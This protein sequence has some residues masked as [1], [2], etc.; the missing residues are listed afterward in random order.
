V[1]CAAEPPARATAAHVGRLQVRH[2]TCVS[3]L[4]TGFLCVAMRLELCVFRFYR[5]RH[6]VSSPSYF[7]SP[8]SACIAGARQA[9]ALRCWRTLAQHGLPV[10][11]LDDMFAP[12]SALLGPPD[13]DSLI[14]GL[15]DG[16]PSAAAAQAR[17]SAIAEAHLLAAALIARARCLPLPLKYVRVFAHV[18]MQGLMPCWLSFSDVSDI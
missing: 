13:W 18:L 14:A 6:M 5:K 11:S 17:L 9:E 4:T 3:S 15:A 1:V 2:F 7:V 16:A 12:L 10:A 8:E